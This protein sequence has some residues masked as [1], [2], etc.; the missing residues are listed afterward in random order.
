MI[1]QNYRCSGKVK[2]LPKDAVDRFIADGFLRIPITKNAY[3]AVAST[4]KTAY[5]FFRASSEEKNLN[6][7]PEDGGYRPFGVEYS[8]SPDS[9]DH[10]ESFTTS[11]RTRTITSK[12][13]TESAQILHQHMLVAFGALESIA[14]TLTIR[15][16]EAIS[17]RLYTEKLRGGFRRWSRLQLNYSRPADTTAAY[18]NE[19][20][21]DGVL[22]TV[23]C[24][25]GPGLEFQ[26]TDGNFKPVTT[27][28]G[29]VL[30]MPGEITWLLSGG[31]IRPLYHRVRPV[32]KY[33]ERLALL[34]LGDIYPSLCEP[35]VTNEVNANID[36]GARVLTSATRFGLQSFA[37]E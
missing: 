9:P 28:S 22:M 6:R 3:E 8:Q 11:D 7:L 4:F 31:L 34:F 1:T 37:L 20:H 27:S 13:P 5:P 16:A 35:W 23:A 10:V 19:A 21:E 33:Q 29:E 17:G 18:I 36:I 30:A 2:F 14:E 32:A 25:T 26:T 24:A 15:L 12:L